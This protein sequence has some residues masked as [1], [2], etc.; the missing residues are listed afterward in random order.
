MELVLGLAA[1]ATAISSVGGANHIKDDS[2]T[3]E[4][5]PS[6]AQTTDNM[7]EYVSKDF[8]DERI[9]GDGF[10]IPNKPIVAE[11][12][13]LKKNEPNETEKTATDLD[14][15]ND[16]FD[17]Y[18]LDGP[19]DHTSSI[20][21]ILSSASDI[22]FYKFTLYG[23]AGIDACLYNPVDHQYDFELYR[24]VETI[25]TNKTDAL[26]TQRIYYASGNTHLS[27][28]EKSLSAGVY[29]VKVYSKDGQFDSAPYTLSLT[30][31]YERKDWDIDVLQDKGAKAALWLCDYDPYGFRPTTSFKPK[32]I[33]CTDHVAWFVFWQH[34][35]NY[36]NPLFPIGPDKPFKQAELFIWD[37]SLRSTLRTFVEGFRDEVTDYFDNHSDQGFSVETAMSGLDL[38]LTVYSLSKVKLFSWVATGFALIS[39][40]SSLLFQ[41]SCTY[42][43]H[44]KLLQY[45]EGIY[46]ALDFTGDTGTREVV[47]IPVWYTVT[48]RKDYQDH[49]EYTSNKKWYT[50][51]YCPMPQNSYKYDRAEHNNTLF[52]HDFEGN[53]PINGTIYPIL[54]E[55]SI[56]DALNERKIHT[57]QTAKSLSLNQEDTVDLWYDESEWYS[58]KAPL[59]GRNTYR[60]ESIGNGGATCDVMDSVVLGNY[61]GNHKIAYV[62]RTDGIVNG[63]FAYE[64]ELNENEIIYFRVHGEVFDYSE[65]YG[66]HYKW[67]DTCSVRVVLPRPSTLVVNGYQL[68]VGEEYTDSAYQT[69]FMRNNNITIS[70]LGCKL[71]SEGKVMMHVDLEGDY[72]ITYFKIDFHRYI[73]TFSFDAYK[74]PMRNECCLF[75][76]TQDLD[77]DPMYYEEI[78]GVDTDFENTKT[79][80]FDFE[81]EHTSSITLKFDPANDPISYWQTKET[82]YLDHFVVEFMD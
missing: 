30:V 32:D 5:Q 22:D 25:D 6:I 81:H 40:T 24:K 7:H 57:L 45:L 50:F 33:G 23:N 27:R 4:A 65:S 63:D 28:I 77:G 79:F 49:I 51:T 13:D 15:L 74:D 56:S 17:S 38:I 10:T 82:I 43:N 44:W 75:L 8:V 19:S 1:L 12:I 61:D 80:S 78:Y 59:L 37:Q 53:N 26:Y 16:K 69:Q 64:F 39:D 67:V 18:K 20:D 73:K 11:K 62:A 48:T 2:N 47:R 66:W 52:S 34:D 60:F 14:D 71:S 54:N 42:D 9:I 68:G 3:A 36:F 41:K 29:Y 31:T 72:P 46:Q 70:K 21:G 35:D 76:S 55:K 58:F